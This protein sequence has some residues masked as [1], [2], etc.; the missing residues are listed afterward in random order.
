MAEYGRIG[1]RCLSLI[2]GCISTRAVPEW[3]YTIDI[4]E[5]SR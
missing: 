3:I 2:Q 1:V 4:S 5:G